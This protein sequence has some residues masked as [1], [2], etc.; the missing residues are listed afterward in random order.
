MSASI[1]TEKE[2]RIFAKD[3]TELNTLINGVR[4]TSEDIDQAMIMAAD[5]FNLFP[6]PTL[7]QYTIETF[8]SRYLLMIGT[9]ANL[10]R[11]AAI[12]QASNEL[13]YSAG[14]VSVDDNNKA[15][16]F[17]ALADKLSQEFEQLASSV[18]MSQNVAQVYGNKYSEFAYRPW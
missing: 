7:N 8:P 5:K 11:G 12:H 14:G 4:F 9:W 17:D 13:A 3:K 15:Q 2:L 6:P 16:L 18:K 1:I 10:L